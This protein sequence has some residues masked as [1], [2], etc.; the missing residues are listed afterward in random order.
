[1]EPRTWR[2]PS[3]II[4]VG[5]AAIP[6]VRR[7]VTI[8][9]VANAGDTVHAVRSVTQPTVSDQ[10]RLESDEKVPMVKPIPRFFQ[11][12]DALS[13]IDVWTDGYRSCKRR[14]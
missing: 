5:T 3:P 8:V 9:E 12:R 7:S 14:L 13:R 4:I 11:C 1:M 2:A 6:A 10:P